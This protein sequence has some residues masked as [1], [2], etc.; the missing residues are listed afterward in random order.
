[1][2]LI[3]NTLAYTEFNTY[4]QK[5]LQQYFI[6]HEIIKDK[7][8]MYPKL[9]YIYLLALKNLNDI[10]LKEEFFKYLLSLSMNISD[11]LRLGR[12]IEHG[13]I[14]YTSDKDNIIGEYIFYLY[15]NNR[16]KLDE[17]YRITVHTSIISTVIRFIVKDL[18]N[19][20]GDEKEVSRLVSEYEN[21]CLIMLYTLDIIAEAH[22]EKWIRWLIKRYKNHLL[23]T[24]YLFIMLR[25]AFAIGEQEWMVNTLNKTKYNS[26]FMLRNKTDYLLDNIANY[27]L[28]KT[29]V[30]ILME[31]YKNSESNSGFKLWFNK[32]ISNQV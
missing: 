13:K 15:K 26:L 20:N 4:S 27:L 28:M 10:Y 24:R 16:I 22:Q 25:E 7:T 18:I 31:M 1:M 14:G 9:L 21:R 2:N 19:N 29:D 8:R 12:Y 30:G 17:I 5:E 6:N 11:I 3:T 32:I 23:F